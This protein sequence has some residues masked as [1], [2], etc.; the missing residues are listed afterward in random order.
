MFLLLL[1]FSFRTKLNK[2]SEENTNYPWLIK[3]VKILSNYINPTEEEK[4]EIFNKNYD[5]LVDINS[6]YLMNMSN[7]K[8]GKKL[9][10]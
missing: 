9:K 1:F 7:Y 10:N 4:L 8:Y 3:L 6:P 5:R 2:L